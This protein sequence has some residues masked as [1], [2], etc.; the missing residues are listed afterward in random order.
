MSD[1]T[2]IHSMFKCNLIALKDSSMYF[3]SSIAG[4]SQSYQNNSFLDH[5]SGPLVGFLVYPKRG[6]VGLAHSEW[7]PSCGTHPVAFLFPTPVSL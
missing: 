7:F 5:L 4:E 2:K 1:Y 3:E 6:K